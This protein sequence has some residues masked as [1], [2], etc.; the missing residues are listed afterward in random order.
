MCFAC[1][2]TQNNNITATFTGFNFV[3]KLKKRTF[4]RNTTTIIIHNSFKQ[5]G[6]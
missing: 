2:I 3:S 4:V 6:R 5:N 1:K